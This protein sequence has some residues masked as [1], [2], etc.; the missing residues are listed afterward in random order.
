[1]AIRVSCPECGNNREFIEI[2]DDVILTTRYVQNED[3]SFNQ[4]VDESQIMGDTNGKV[5]HV[6]ERDCSIQRRHQ[7]LIEEAPSPGLDQEKS[8]GGT[9]VFCLHNTECPAWTDD[10]PG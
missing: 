7:K 8:R 5:M 1:M 6:G 10:C 4:E 2:A 3:G 9:A